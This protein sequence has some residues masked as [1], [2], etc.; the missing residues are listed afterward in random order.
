M[1]TICTKEELES[2]IK[3]SFSVKDVLIAIGLSP[4][5][6]NYQTIKRKIKLFNLDISHFVGCG[7]LKNKSHNWSRRIPLEKILVKDSL[8]C[9]TSNL[10]RR[11]IKGGYLENK[12]YECGLTEWRGKT[13]SLEL[14]HINGDRFDN[15]IGNLTILCP[16]CHS[17]TPTYRRQKNIV[18]KHY[19]CTRCSKKIY[20]S[21]KSKLCHSC[22]WIVRNENRIIKPLKCRPRK[23]NV[24]KKELDKMIKKMSFAQIGKHFGVSDNA[25]RKRARL[26]DLI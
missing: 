21:N 5:G 7:H 19:K 6:G 10:R 3:K 13:I 22:Y 4:V 20:S 12:C 26:F 15:R 11:L 2:I 23:F 8:Y 17:Q 24:E 18:R 16:N 9:G 14:E 25:I 1:S